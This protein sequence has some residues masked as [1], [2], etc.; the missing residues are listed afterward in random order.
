MII[1]VYFYILDDLSPS[2]SPAL[3]RGAGVLVPPSLA[4]K[5]VRGLGF[6]KP[7]AAE[8]SCVES[9]SVLGVLV[10]LLKSCSDIITSLTI[11]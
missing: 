7:C 6:F 11:H 1:G 4:G 3:E 9:L 5:G 2:P 10:T 8:F